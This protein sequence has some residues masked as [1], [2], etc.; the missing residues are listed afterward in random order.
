LDEKQLLGC[1]LQLTRWII[2]EKWLM[3]SVPLVSL[4]V[5]VGLANWLAS[6]LNMKEV[7]AVLNETRWTIGT[8]TIRK[9]DGIMVTMVIRLVELRMLLK[10]MM[11]LPERLRSVTHRLKYCTV[12]IFSW[13]YLIMMF[14]PKSWWRT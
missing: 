2:L 5:V 3:K 1:N 11:L 9:S 10:V 8:G 12:N 13:R 7:R 14:L 4:T 6:V